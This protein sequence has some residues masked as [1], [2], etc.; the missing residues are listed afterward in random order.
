MSFPPPPR[1]ILRSSKELESSLLC[2]EQHV[3]WND[4]EITTGFQ[5]V[6]DLHSF[7]SPFLDKSS[8][9]GP[10][11]FNLSSWWTEFSRENVGSKG[12]PSPSA[13]IYLFKAQKCSPQVDCCLSLRVVCLQWCLETLSFPST[14]SVL[15]SVLTGYYYETHTSLELVIL[16]S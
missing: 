9:Y 5:M 7:L 3:C 6:S 8:I 14:G 15:L 11:S 10:H 16:W 1:W 4:R 13:F 2:L 12:F